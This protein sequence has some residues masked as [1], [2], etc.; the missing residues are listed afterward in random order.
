MIKVLYDD[1]IFSSQTTGGVSRYFS[2]VISH[3]DLI[4]DVSISL[5]LI[6][7]ANEYIRNSDIF[8]GVGVTSRFNFKGRRILFRLINRLPLIHA[9]RERRFDVFHFTYYDVNLLKYLEDQA[10]VIT[11]HDLIPELF[12]GST[13]SAVIRSGLIRLFPIQS[14]KRQLIERA[15]RIVAV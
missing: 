8:H 11:I 1:E 13:Y 6:M 7:T 2:E 9:L 4:P 5:P 12:Y 15:A 3:L 10:F 14:L